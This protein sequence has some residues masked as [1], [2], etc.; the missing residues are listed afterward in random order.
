MKWR[1]W[2]YFIKPWKKFSSNL[3]STREKCVLLNC[4]NFCRTT[5]VVCMH[6]CMYRQNFVVICCIG[7]NEFKF[8]CIVV[9]Y[10]WSC[11]CEILMKIGSFLSFLLKLRPHLSNFCHSTSFNLSNDF[12]LI[13]VDGDSTDVEHFLLVKGCRSTEICDRPFV[14]PDQRSWTILVTS[15]HSIDVNLNSTTDR[16]I[17]EMLSFV[18]ISRINVNVTSCATVSFSF[19]HMTKSDEVER[20]KLDGWINKDAALERGIYTVSCILTVQNFTQKF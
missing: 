9:E 11:P 2:W 19:C 1:A 12:C 20:Q 15:F 7:S 4:G 5:H 3:F 8:Y 18:Q 14:S 6:V 13:R 16:S 10:V 17:D